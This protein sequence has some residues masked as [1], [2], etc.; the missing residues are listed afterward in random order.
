[1]ATK[2]KFS[3]LQLDPVR[4]LGFR[5]QRASDPSVQRAARLSV[6]IAHW[7]NAMA[8]DASDDGV[9]YDDDAYGDEEW[10]ESS[11]T[12]PSDTV[13]QVH[14]LN[15]SVDAAHTTTK[16]DP[17]TGGEDGGYSDGE[18]EGGKNDGGTASSGN[19]SS[20]ENPPAALTYAR[21]DKDTDRSEA[22]P[23]AES[24]V[25]SQTY[26]KEK[27]PLD[28]VRIHAHRNQ[29]KIAQPPPAPSM[30]GAS[31]RSAD[32]EK[33]L[34]LLRISEKSAIVAAKRVVAFREMQTQNEAQRAAETAAL[35][36]KRIALRASDRKIYQQMGVSHLT[37]DQRYQLL[38][39]E[40]QLMKKHQKAVEKLEKQKRWYNVKTA[41][42]DSKKKK[43][44]AAAHVAALKEREL[45]K[46]K[47]WYRET[48]LRDQHIKIQ[49]DS[50]HNEAKAIIT[51]CTQTEY[52]RGSYLLKVAATKPRQS[53][54][55][56]SIPSSQ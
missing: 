30:P 37:G 23:T 41:T 54:L 14:P 31:E 48:V 32:M 2:D 43:N 18:F 1:M 10:E 52:V 15:A 33:R 44:M 27:E 36:N 28:L 51:A 49:K 29:E 50:L 47:H 35:K 5:Q 8:G 56:K 22:E 46:R 39:E 53:S 55:R 12:K 4:A 24:E 26:A 11:V 42:S 13:E 16:L 21:S 40:Q 20:I 17:T 45:E 25:S 6:Y 38:V 9:Q 7:G 19:A 3:Q 34:Q